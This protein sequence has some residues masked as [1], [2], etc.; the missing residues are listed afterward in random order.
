[1]CFPVNF[2]EISKNTF[3]ERTPAVAASQNDKLLE[4]EI[5][6]ILLKCISDHLSVSFR[7]A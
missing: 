1:M 3:S 2:Y 4:C 5:F 6:R 7:F